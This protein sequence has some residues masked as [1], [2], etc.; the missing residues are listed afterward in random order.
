MPFL[1]LCLI[2][3]FKHQGIN[4]DVWINELDLTIYIG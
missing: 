4:L 2:N 3:L 1:F